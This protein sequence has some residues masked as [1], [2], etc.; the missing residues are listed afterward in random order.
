[1]GLERCPLSL[2]SA[3]EELLGRKSSGSGLESRDYG[4]RDPSRR[5]RGTFYPL[6]LAL[7]SPI[8]G[9]LSADIVPRG[10]RP[11]SLVQ[12]GL[13]KILSSSGPKSN[14]TEQQA[15]RRL[16]FDPDDGSSTLL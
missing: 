11:R 4:R 12:F 5:P 14:A 6:K 13:Y 10:F 1:V 15:I 2:V 3:T 9:G 16:P 8:R 7:P